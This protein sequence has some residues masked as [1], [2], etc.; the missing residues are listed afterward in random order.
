MSDFLKLC[1]LR[2]GESAVVH[3]VADPA[4]P[5]ADRLRDLGLTAGSAVT[6][7]MQSPLGDP[8]AYLVRGAVIA[9]RRRD[10]GIVSV[11]TGVR[12]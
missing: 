9:L 11:R 4:H 10:A 1:D 8:C 12:G 7:T 3:T 2:P 5:L 6:C